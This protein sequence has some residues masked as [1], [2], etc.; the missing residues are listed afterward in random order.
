[1]E[2]SSQYITKKDMRGQLYN[3]YTV[4]SVAFISGGDRVP[5]LVSAKTCDRY[6]R[7]L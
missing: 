5:K 1:M 7:S 4:F 6:D 3:M 2:I